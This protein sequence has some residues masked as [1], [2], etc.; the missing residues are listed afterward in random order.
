MQV[1]MLFSIMDS[2]GSEILDPDTGERLGSVY[3]PKVVV[4][5]VVVDERLAIARTYNQSRGYAT[6]NSFESLFG[7][8]SQPQIETLKTDEPTWDDMPVD[9]IFIRIGDP[10]VQVAAN[11]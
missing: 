9:E 1:D 8:R 3:R 7:G 4:K 10:V 2:E 5:V 6:S 11:E